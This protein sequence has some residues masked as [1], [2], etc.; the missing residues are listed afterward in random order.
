MCIVK[1]PLATGH[2]PPAKD[3]FK[4]QAIVAV[5]LSLMDTSL[6]IYKKNFHSPNGSSFSVQNF[7]LGVFVN[8]IPARWLQLVPLNIHPIPH[9]GTLAL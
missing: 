1:R 7:T 9:P 2:R 5:S 4:F 3:K 8:K 6:S